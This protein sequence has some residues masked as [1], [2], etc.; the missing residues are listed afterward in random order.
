MQYYSHW[1]YYVKYQLSK[2]SDAVLCSTNST[3]IPFP[4]VTPPA[5]PINRSVN[6]NSFYWYVQTTYIEMFST[7]IN[8]H[9][10]LDHSTD[11]PDRLSRSHWSSISYAELSFVAHFSLH[12]KK[13]RTWNMLLLFLESFLTRELFPVPTAPS[14]RTLWPINTASSKLNLRDQCLVWFHVR[15]AFFV[16]FYE[17]LYMYLIYV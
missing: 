3:L 4:V 9:S 1:N 13:N 2:Q 5:L 17:R 10:I 6:D 12:T 7:F 16:N 14:I 8:R 15:V 11:Q